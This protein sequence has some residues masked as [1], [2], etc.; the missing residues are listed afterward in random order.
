VEKHSQFAINPSIGE[1]DDE[2]AVAQLAQIVGEQQT[3]IRKTDGVETE[4]NELRDEVIRDRGRGAETK[5]DDPPHA[6]DAINRFFERLDGYR[7]AQA[8]KRAKMQ[9]YGRVEGGGQTAANLAQGSRQPLRRR[10]RAA[11][12]VGESSP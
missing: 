7:P 5:D 8:L 9:I 2:I 4:T 3:G 6:G 10:E 11:Q 12:F 1:H